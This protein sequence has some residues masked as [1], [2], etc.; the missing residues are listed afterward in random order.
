M[1]LLFFEIKRIFKSPIFYISLAIIFGFTFIQ[2]DIND[3]IYDEDPAL[4]KKRHEEMVRKAKKEVMDGEEILVYEN[5]IIYEEAGY[6]SKKTD[7]ISV[8][9]ENSVERLIYEF[10]ENSYATYP[11]GF[12]KEIQLSN[13]EQEQMAKYLSKLT[14]KSLEEVKNSSTESEFYK[15]LNYSTTGKKEFLKIMS[16]VDDLLGGG[17]YYSEKKII[18]K[19]GDAPMDYEDAVEDYNIIKNKDKFTGAYA[20][21]FCD[22]LGIIIS[23]APILLAVYMWYQDKTS[24]AL[25]IVNSK[26][27]GSSKLV[28]T[29]ILAMFIVFT[30]A[31]F[32]LATIYNV[33]VIS[34]YGVDNVDI[35]TFYKYILLWILPNLLFVLAFGTLITI[36]TN[37]PVGIVGMLVLWIVFIFGNSNNLYGGYGWPL[38]LRHSTI[39]NTE[40][41][42]NN[43]GSVYTN[44]VIYTVISV[45]FIL[46]AIKI[47]DLK[48][49]G[50]MVKIERIGNNRK[51]RA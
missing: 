51:K 5:S 18:S 19:Y 31:I 8:V 21:L 11:F 32:I 33:K 3:D 12:L 9:Q 47:F 10:N 42:F 41:Y 40:F 43:I 4:A 50:G 27:V 15:S 2:M 7:D 36:L 16:S 46:L 20:R 1:K 6:G 17:S 29:R 22:Y 23:F 25:E 35:F 28:L 37:Y 24:G 45:A 49:N 14:G 30:L 44:R 34:V 38:I 48:R 26:S 39:G 13:G